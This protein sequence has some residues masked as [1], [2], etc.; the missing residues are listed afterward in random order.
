MTL[1]AAVVLA[2]VMLGGGTGC[3]QRVVG[4]QNDWVG[5][6]YRPVEREEPGMGEKMG[7][8]MRNTGHFLF[9]WT[10]LTGD[11]PRRQQRLGDLG[12]VEPSERGGSP[13][14]IRTGEY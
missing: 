12:D 14:R 13:Q 1:T 2:A 7:Q 10:G 5:S 3:E 11:K 8:G 4:T 6:Q 9:G